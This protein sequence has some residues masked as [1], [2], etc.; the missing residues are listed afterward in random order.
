MLLLYIY[1]VAIHYSNSKDFA[2]KLL[3]KS[4]VM[5]TYILYT[6]VL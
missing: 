5:S 1:I 6:M 3:E 2:K 4:L